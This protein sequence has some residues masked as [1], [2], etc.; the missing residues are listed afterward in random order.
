MHTYEKSVSNNS[1]VVAPSTQ[2]TGSVIWLHGLG[3]D[4]NDFVPLVSELNLSNNLPLRFVFPHAPLRPVTINNGYV[5]RAWF[6]IYSM[7][8][9]QRIDEEG[10]ANSIELVHQLIENEQKCG[11]L[12]ENIILAGF[13]QGA[14]MALRTGLH[15][16]KPLAGILA[17]SGFLPAEQMAAESNKA[18]RATPIFIAH[19]S[20]DR[21]VPFIL[22]EDTANALK[23]LHYPVTWKSYPIPHS[24]CAEEV[25]D[26]AKW[27]KEVYKI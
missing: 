27:L 2:A 9:D 14:V 24:V 11:I 1:I 23:T 4:G 6:D 20:Q 7:K 19:G 26:I 25:S 18:N 5:M 12:S 3:A 22:G 8:L 17:L 16:P 15:Y 10:I 13:S 21:V